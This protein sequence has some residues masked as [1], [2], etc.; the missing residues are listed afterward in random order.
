VYVEHDREQD[1]VAQA[2]TFH[3]IASGARSGRRRTGD[4]CDA[5]QRSLGRRASTRL[6]RR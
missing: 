6:N 3:A 5:L 2:V 1:D 4:L